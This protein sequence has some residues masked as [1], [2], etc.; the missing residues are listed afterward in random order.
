MPVSETEQRGTWKFDGTISLG[1]ILLLGGMCVSLTVWML[2]GRGEVENAQRDIASLKETVSAQATTT[3]ESIRE[4]M[5]RVEANLGGI[6][7]Q[8]QQ[9]PPLAERLRRVEADIARLQEAD[10][11]LSTRIENRRN[12]IDGRINVLDAKVGEALV[13]LEGM[14]RAS[15]VALPGSP[16]VRR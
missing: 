12:L 7:A 10:S 11:D 4:S 6:N 9:L 1:N 16:G 15:G 13:R 2:S 8:V 3:R 5:A 14:S